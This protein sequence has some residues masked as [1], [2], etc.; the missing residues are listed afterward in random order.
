M[1]QQELTTED[2]E[3]LAP[4]RSLVMQYVDLPGAASRRSSLF[5]HEA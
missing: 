4:L 5:P 2:G 3:P 1:E